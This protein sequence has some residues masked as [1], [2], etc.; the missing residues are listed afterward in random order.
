MLATTSPNRATC[1]PL[2]PSQSARRIAGRLLLI[3]SSLA[4]LSACTNG[5]IVTG[6]T[7]TPNPIRAEAPTPSDGDFL[8][9]LAGSD[10]ATVTTESLEAGESLEASVTKRG[11]GQLRVVTEPTGA[12]GIL[13][14]SH[15]DADQGNLAAVRLTSKSGALDVEDRDFSIGA[16]VRLSGEA[17]S[18]E[19]DNGDNVVQRGL[20]GSTGQY[21][22]QLDNGRPSC[23]IS[24]Q[25]G[26]V[27]AK[28]DVSVEPDTWYR[29]VCRR[30]GNTVTLFV[31]PVDSGQSENPTQWDI[32]QVVGR[33]GRVKFVQDDRYLSIGAKINRQ[34]TIVRN[35]P[36]QFNG[37]IDRV[38]L[39]IDK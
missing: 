2:H 27:V 10:P 5:G 12:S 19:Q 3:A 4:V 35:S 1:S 32:V 17:E 14:P 34:G 38:F 22:V 39:A 37:G 7:E 20:Y 30:D 24:G 28:S 25:L 16:D 31:A 13:F 6:E 21:K 18:S 9:E 36:D 29:L 23:R 11:S 15:A 8:L 33:T 26:S